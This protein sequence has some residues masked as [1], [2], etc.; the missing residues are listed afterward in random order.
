MSSKVMKVQV[1]S[2]LMFSSRDFFVVNEHLLSSP[3][4]DS[5]LE[6]A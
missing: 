6:N 3:L 1:A 2:L 5:T 4:D